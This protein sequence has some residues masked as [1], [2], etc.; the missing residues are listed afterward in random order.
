[1]YAACV[2]KATV[3]FEIEI[4]KKREKSKIIVTKTEVK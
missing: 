2:N 4:D 1:M 3:K